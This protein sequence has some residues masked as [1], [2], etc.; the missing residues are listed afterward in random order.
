MH[1]ILKYE[2]YI[3]Y[4]RNPHLNFIR[5]K[6]PQILLCILF[7]HLSPDIEVPVVSTETKISNPVSM[8]MGLHKSKTIVVK[9]SALFM[10][11]ALGGS[12]ILQSIMSDW[13]HN[14][15]ARIRSLFLSSTSNSCHDYLSPL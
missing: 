15:Y 2:E 12:F 14:R 11:D 13:F 3:P 10:L 4:Y 1:M 5:G 7:F 9:L 6:L 8:F